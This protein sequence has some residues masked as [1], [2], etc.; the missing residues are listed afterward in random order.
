MGDITYRNGTIADDR[1]IAEHFYQLWLDNHVLRED[2][3]A[4]WQAEILIF[5]AQARKLLAYQS[6]IAEV[7]GAIIGSVGCQ[8]FAGLYPIPFQL[9][10]R[11]DGYIW[12]VYVA[13]K[14]RRQ[15]IG[16]ALTQRSVD[17]L[18]EI[19]CTRAVLNAS[20]SGKPIYERL[21]FQS[22]NA[23]VLDLRSSQ[24]NR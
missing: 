6:F 16:R 13:P 3:R 12:G 14:Y 15:G 18:R 20:P 11:Q 9:H 23:M 8:I 10:Y 17:Y 21:G 5:I 2:I 1:A 7:D 22:H 19:G 4:D 24:E